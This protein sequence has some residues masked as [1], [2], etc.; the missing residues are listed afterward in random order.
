[1]WWWYKKRNVIKQ[2][3]S[4]FRTN[5]FIFFILAKYKLYSLTGWLNYIRDTFEV[6]SVLNE[7]LWPKFLLFY[8]W[9]IYKLKCL[10]KF[11]HNILLFLRTKQPFSGLCPDCLTLLIPYTLMELVS[12][13]SEFDHFLKEKMSQIISVA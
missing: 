8:S 6:I 13:F 2:I 3:L 4:N 10:I 5:I 1:M 12:L 11:I 7:H 9:N